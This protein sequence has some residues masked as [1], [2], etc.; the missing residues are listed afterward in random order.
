MKIAVFG[1]YGHD[2]AGDERIK[3][4]LQSFLMGL[5]GI[6]TIDFYDLHNEAVKGPT[7]KFDDY[8]LVIIGGGGLI[9]S[10]HNYHDFILGINTKMVTLGISVETDLK[11]N[12]KKFAEALLEKSETILVRDKSSYEKFKVFDTH[13]KVILSVDMTFLAPYDLV[14]DQKDTNK[15][16][17]NLLSKVNEPPIM[18]QI[19]LQLL[20]FSSKLSLKTL[21]FKD[22]IHDLNS[23][24]SLIPIPLFCEE[25]KENTPLF[26]ANDITFLKQYFNNVS[27][28]FD[29]TNLDSCMAFLS[30]RL[31]G[32]I[33][34][35]QKGIPFITFSTYPKQENFMR[36]VGLQEFCLDFHKSEQIKDKLSIILR[37]KHIIK[38]I[39]LAYRAK[40]VKQSKED[41]IQIMNQFLK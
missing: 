24:Y 19:K 40:A 26:Q 25:K 7:S 11:G 6:K 9:L 1:W 27:N 12:P 8:N 14:L 13:K 29:H 28:T 23:K 18:R 39:I 5:G 16:A 4:C 31:H 33:F 38:E 30:M 21:S 37:N 35:A 17:I 32:L 15:L 36:E 3:Y 20:R 2:N 10:R 34:A 22:L 41:L